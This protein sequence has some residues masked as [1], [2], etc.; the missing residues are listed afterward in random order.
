MVPGKKYKILHLSTSD[1]GG[2][3]IASLRMYRALRKY[4]NRCEHIFMVM[5]KYTKENDIRVFG[6]FADIWVTVKSKL[7]Q[8]AIK[9]LSLGKASVY[10][11][12]SCIPSLIHNKINGFG[13]DLIHIH[14]VQGEML[15]IESVGRLKADVVIT[16][17]DMWP[18]LGASHYSTNEGMGDMLERWCSSRKSH[19]VPDR[20]N[21]HY[22]TNWM[23][24]QGC[25][26]NSPYAL[27]A[28]RFLVIGYPL[29]TD[30]FKPGSK[31]HNRR[32]WNIPVDSFVVLF[33]A[34]GGTSDKRKGWDYFKSALMQLD[35]DGIKV[36]VVIFGGGQQSHFKELEKLKCINIRFLGQIHGDSDMARVYSIADL[37]VVPSLIEAFGQTASEAQSCGVPVIA[38]NTSGLKEVVEHQVS[39]LLVPPKDSRAIANAI[40][41]LYNNTRLLE[42]MSENARRRSVNL[43]SEKY[44]A[45][46]MSSF[47]RH[48]LQD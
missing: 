24:E 12:P 48:A 17:H 8:F 38:S 1:K 32:F 37:M 41:Y 36:E 4:D 43:W 40:A 42:V 27:A 33:G 47:Y 35:E 6:R 2:A 23:K 28:K 22:T 16:T 31:R 19:N 44:F 46:K 34:V 7:V 45:Q 9:L 39:G 13:C 21:F 29:N 20:L 30:V 11:S 25:F 5:H 18:I 3:S 15:S 26:L 14:W 10:R